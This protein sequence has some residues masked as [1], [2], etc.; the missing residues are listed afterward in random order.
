MLTVSNIRDWLA[1]LLPGDLVYAGF[2]DANQTHCIG[3]YQRDAGDWVQAIGEDSTYQRFECKLLIHWG[4]D[5]RDCEAKAEAV[6]NLLK[7]NR[8]STISTHQL[9]GIRLARPPI[10]VGRDA[11]GIFES[12][13]LCTIMYN[14]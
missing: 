2:I 3:V 11:N 1:A 7:A 5:I 9:A 12:I 6:F 10:D 14:V 4:A 13:V 8:K